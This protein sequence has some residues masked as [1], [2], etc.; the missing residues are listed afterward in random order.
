MIKAIFFDIDGTLVSHK[1]NDIPMTTR[2]CLKK[3]QEKGIKIFVSTGRHLVEMN[4]MPTNNI[5]FDGY[6]TLNGNICL[7]QNF[8]YVYGTPFSENITQKLVAFFEKNEFP[9]VLIENERFYINYYNHD[10]ELAQKSISTPLPDKSSYCGKDIFQGTLF[11]K[12]EDE[13]KVLHHL[14]EGCKFTRWS[15]LAVD[16][17]STTSG[18][19]NG[20]KHFLNELNIQREEIMTF[21]DSE[22]DIDMI[23]FAGIGI[24]MGNASDDVKEVADYVTS[25]VDDDGILSALEHFHV[26]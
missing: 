16:I 1:I 24:A 15:P 8:N 10:V 23:K 5:S 22:N 13:H 12:K 17:I 3:L 20:I 25:S 4:D 7:D 2:N 14:P 6:V 11:I 19:V 18:K 9:L 21:G 26:I